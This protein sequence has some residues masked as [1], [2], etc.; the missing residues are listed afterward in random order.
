MIVD[1]YRLIEDLPLDNSTLDGCLSLER[2]EENFCFL[3]RRAG[4]NVDFMDVG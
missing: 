2:E 3:C 1:L 4:R